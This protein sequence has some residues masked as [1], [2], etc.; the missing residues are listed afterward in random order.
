M[1]KRYNNKYFIVFG[2]LGAGLSVLWKITK[3]GKVSYLFGTLHTDDEAIVTLSKEVKQAFDNAVLCAFEFEPTLSYV[4]FDK[5]NVERFSEWVNREICPVTQDRYTNY[6]IHAK[7]TIVS[8][9]PKHTSDANQI[10]FET[11]LAKAIDSY[12]PIGFLHQLYW[13]SQSS[14]TLDMQFFEQAH[15]QKKPVVH[16]EEP[17]SLM[18]TFGGYSFSFNEHMELY[19]ERTASLPRDKREFPESGYINAP[20]LIIDYLSNSP[21]E[22]LADKMEPKSTVSKKYHRHLVENRDE[23]FVNKLKPYFTEG[24]VFAVVG[25]LHLQGMLKKL[26]QEGYSVEPVALSAREHPINVENFA[27]HSSLQ[28]LPIAELPS[29]IDRIK[30][31]FLPHMKNSFSALKILCAIPDEARFE[32]IYKN[33]ASELGDALHSLTEFLS[34]IAQEDISEIKRRLIIETM[35]TQLLDKL[36][37]NLDF[38]RLITNLTPSECDLLYATNRATIFD[39]LLEPTAVHLQP[40]FSTAQRDLADFKE[41][42]A[43]FSSSTR[44]TTFGIALLMGSDDEIKLHFTNLV[45]STNPTPEPLAFFK[46]P[47]F[48]S[49]Q[50][51]KELLNLKIIYK[52]KIMRAL[53]FHQ[54]ADESDLLFNDFIDFILHDWQQKTADFHL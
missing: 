51:R 3:N 10:E 12:T 20:P 41:L 45:A 9:L 47:Q 22:S 19:E 28:E 31:S 11:A 53:N 2:Y 50:L 13:L 34:L 37:S 30:G 49:K 42:G 14:D 29:F 32:I 40:L 35:S 24:G 5:W 21:L 27:N 48:T 54:G 6:K 4:D 23:I 46:T 25:V 15:L 43:F 1:N 36:R 16:I 26:A 33:L 7:K 52:E 8:L 44:A 17:E 38:N 18:D 39:L